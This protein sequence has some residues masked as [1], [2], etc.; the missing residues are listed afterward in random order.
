MTARRD[1]K[2]RVRDRTAKTGESYTA[3]L[4]HFLSGPREEDR[5]ES[6][7]SGQ[8]E[9]PDPNGRLNKFSVQAQRVLALAQE[10]AEASGRRYVA[11]A[12]LL[13]ALA[14]R[15]DAAL[16]QAFIRLGQNPATFDDWIRQTESI[17]EP[18]PE[19]LVGPTDVVRQSLELAVDLAHSAGK[20][21]VEPS[22]IFLGL[23]S[24]EPLQEVVGR[25][26]SAQ[27]HLFALVADILAQ[28]EVPEVGPSEQ[29][30]RRPQLLMSTDVMR[31]VQPPPRLLRSII[32]VGQAEE[33]DGVSVT[34]LHIEDY[35]TAFLAT[36]CAVREHSEPTTEL[37]PDA[38]ETPALAALRPPVRLPYLRTIAFDDLGGRYLG[39]VRLSPIGWGPSPSESFCW[40]FT[41]AFAPAIDSNARLLKLLVEEIHWPRAV[42]GPTR[43][44]QA[45]SANIRPEEVTP[46][47]WTFAVPIGAK[48][49]KKRSA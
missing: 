15:P 28:T 24:T 19:G 41:Y 47:P 40:R 8:T 37:D 5:M 9:E 12:D 30:V 25:G 45:M 23:L 36:L 34:L 18:A 1:F 10:R 11:S 20:N 21:R 16:Q 17:A 26:R 3:A 32:P 42:W 44:G 13:Y 39:S 29:V 22:H 49:S 4:R 48:R 33:L 31:D 43:R 2:K 6:Q 14:R 38:E 7:R 35:G 27:R 46:G